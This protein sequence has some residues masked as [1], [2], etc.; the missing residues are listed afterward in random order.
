MMHIY[1]VKLGTIPW[2]NIATEKPL[3]VGDKFFIPNTDSFKTI[4][5]VWKLKVGRSIQ[6]FIQV[7]VSAVDN[8][9]DIVFLSRM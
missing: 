5:P 8:K 9:E 1:R 2:A 4:R 3:A 6:P 7:I